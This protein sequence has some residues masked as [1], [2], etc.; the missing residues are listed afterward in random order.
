MLT[1]NLIFKKIDKSRI[2]SKRNYFHTYKMDKFY[3]MI[4]LFHEM[5]NEKEMLMKL[6]IPILEF[7]VLE[8]FLLTNI[9][10][11]FIQ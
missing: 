8:H 3:R 2:V 5:D 7:I 9:I 11:K 10:K 6:D 4:N 1:L